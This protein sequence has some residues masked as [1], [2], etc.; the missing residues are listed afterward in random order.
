MVQINHNQSES[1]WDDF[2]ASLQ[3][4]LKIIIFSQWP[5]KYW[6]TNTNQKIL[7]NKKTKGLTNAN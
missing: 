4:F 2:F 5:A 7:E 1:N 6:D 3:F